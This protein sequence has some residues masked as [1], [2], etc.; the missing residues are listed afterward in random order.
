MLRGEG[1]G[2]TIITSSV[3]GAHGIAGLAPYAASKGGLN[4]LVK[5]TAV[6]WATRGVRVNGIAPGYIENIMAGV[7][8]RPDDPYQRRAM[9]RTPMGR[10]GRLHEFVGAYLFLASEAA[11]YITG[12]ILYVDGGFH[13]A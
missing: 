7:A 10:R 11:S 12:T 3:A 6:E 13:A 9:E 5:T 1:G 2:S 8:Y 4:Q